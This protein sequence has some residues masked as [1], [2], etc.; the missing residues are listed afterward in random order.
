MSGKKIPTG[1]F[2][3]TKLHQYGNGDNVPGLGVL[4]KARNI[5]IKLKGKKYKQVWDSF[6][7]EILFE[8]CAGS[9]G[10]NLGLQCCGSVSFPHPCV[11]HTSF[12]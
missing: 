6:P 8:W 9:T 11:I 3:E 2:L 5:V 12:E 4:L 1:H 10:F 7:M